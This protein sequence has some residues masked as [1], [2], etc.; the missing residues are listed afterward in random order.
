MSSGT[1]LPRPG[2]PSVAIDAANFAGV[3]VPGILPPGFNLD[4]A[5]VLDVAARVKE[6]PVAIIQAAYARSARDLTKRSMWLKRNITNQPLT[7]NQ[8]AYNFGTDPNLEV[9]GIDSG[10][11]PAAEF[12]LDQPCA[13]VIR[14]TSTRT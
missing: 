11:D 5:A 7:I 12:D 10:P 2:P 13:K 1:F 9:I 4:L 6:A 3:Q 8:P 14:T